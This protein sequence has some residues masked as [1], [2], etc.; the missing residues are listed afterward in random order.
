M[1]PRRRSATVL[2]LTLLVGACGYF[3]SYYNAQRRFSEAERAARRGATSEATSAYAD[4]IARAAVSYRKHPDSRWSDDALLLI[5]RARFAMGEHEA[6]RA[7]LG[8]VLEQSRD[9]E[10]RA[11][12]AI[13]LGAALVRLGRADSA[14]APLAQGLTGAE[15]GSELQALGR[16][17]LGRAHLD[18]GDPAGWDELATAA[19]RAGP[20]ATEALLEQAA[21]G[22]AVGDSVRGLHALAQLTREEAAE[23]RLD[24]TLALVRRAASA[25]GGT[26]TAAALPGGEIDGWQSDTR[27]R[28]G[29]ER[30]LLLASAGDTAA[31][32][33]AALTAAER[34]AGTISGQA[35]E[36]AAGW[37]LGVADS[38]GDLVRVRA[39]LLPAVTHEGA[40]RQ[41]RRVRTLDVLL[42][43]ARGGQTAALFAAA[44]FARDTLRSPGLAHQLFLAYADV[45]ASTVWAPKALL[46]ALQL[47]V[48]SEQVELRQRIRQYGGNP[49]VAAAQGESP[50]PAAYSAAE[51]RLGRAV[52]AVRT[53][54]A[55][56]ALAGDLRVGRAVA[57]LDSLRLLART[58]SMRLRCGSLLDSLTLHGIRADSV[59]AA[60]LRSDSAGITRFLAIDTLQLRDSVATR[61]ARPKVVRDTLQAP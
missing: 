34:S 11:A 42:D 39:V 29:L 7:A 18:R 36:L 24:S 57:V 37:L 10:L 61:G 53:D 58:D 17:W 49:Y 54:A 43:R 2:L 38:I 27:T 12:A 41:V 16:L 60:C 55:A 28:V 15:T 56:A 48:E 23:S 4:A 50:D 59:R 40:L 22:I 21:R 3:N 13:Y 52:E 46:A 1:S 31:A 44:E 33:A 6:A 19:A 5:G 9:R 32:I 14:L 30:A 26:R 35:R 47:A 20:L 25:W 45:G 8:R 51:E